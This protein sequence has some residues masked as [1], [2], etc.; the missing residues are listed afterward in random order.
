MGKV[1][2]AALGAWLVGR[3]SGI[4]IRGTQEEINAIAN[5]MMASKRF[6]DE[7]N[8]DGATVDSVVQKLGLKNASIKEFERILQIR[9]PL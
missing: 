9:W 5:A 1:F 4:K 2:F 3:L 7:L 8:R 6:Q